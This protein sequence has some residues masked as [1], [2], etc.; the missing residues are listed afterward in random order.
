MGTVPGVRVAGVVETGQII[1]GCGVK[2]TDNLGG[3]GR[4]YYLVISNS[5][6]VKG[7]NHLCFLFSFLSWRG[8]KLV[9]YCQLQSCISD[10][11]SPSQRSMT[12]V[13][14]TC[15]Q[16]TI[17]THLDTKVYRL[18]RTSVWLVGDR[19][20]CSDIQVREDLSDCDMIYRQDIYPLH[21]AATHA[22]SAWVNDWAEALP[23]H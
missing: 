3:I 18:W 22:R 9:A 17:Q 2:T 4:H 7:C 21:P 13:M 12:D 8:L 11:L 5:G 14:S 23:L 15:L 19:I 16:L 10:A 1:F 20:R 6:R